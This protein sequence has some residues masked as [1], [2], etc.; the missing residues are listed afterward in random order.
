VAVQ[1]DTAKREDANRTIAA[2]VDNFGRIDILANNAQTSKQGK[3]EDITDEG[4]ALASDRAFTAP[5]IICR[6]A[7]PFLKKQGGSVLNLGS[8]QGIYGEPGD[9]AYG[10]NRKQSAPFRA[11][12][13]E[14]GASSASA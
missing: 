10:A 1:G 14:S 6:R 8:R 13:P 12:P 11:R 2:A 5:F 9:G 3:I 4:L 7:F